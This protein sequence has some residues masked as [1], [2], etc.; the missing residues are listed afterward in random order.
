M[1]AAYGRYAHFCGSLGLELFEPLSFKGR[2][3]SGRAGDRNGYADASLRP[4]SGDWEK[5]LYTYRLWGRLLYNPEATPDG[6][7][8][9]LAAEFGPAAAD[10]E[11][12]LASASRV[13][14]LVTTA[15][16]PSAS[17]NAF[18]PEI[19][20]N[21]PIVDANRPHHYGDTPSP[22]RFGTVSPLDPAL[23][24]TVEECAEELASGRRTGRYSPLEVARWLD[25]FTQEAATR[26]A[27][28]RTLAPADDPRFRRLAIDVSIQAGLGRFFAEKLR[29]AVAY[30]I[31]DKTHGTAA[32]REA[33][34][35]YR[36][37][38]DAWAKL[39]AE[40][41]GIYVD[42]LTFGAAPHL[43]GHWADRLAAIDA[44]LADMDAE[45]NQASVGGPEQESGS[46]LLVAY[47]EALTG[48]GD[49]TPRCQHQPPPSFRP[50]ES[51][52]IEITSDSGR[53]LE[54]VRLHYR[55][56]NQAEEYQVVP[57]SA[58]GGRWRAV[59]PA[60]YTDSPYPL[61][62]YFELHDA[63][64]AAW[65]YP[66]LGENLT[67]QPYFVIRRGDKLPACPPV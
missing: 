31:Y 61:L 57:M 30:A 33:M 36:P 6:W 42:D 54:S 27:R 41:Q 16:D 55:H 3:G 37:A 18:W 44:D 65:L 15:H 2:K 19:Y 51:V 66:G 63:H 5:H 48:R 60:S 14:P 56:V 29:A 23:F 58:E 1:A 67:N 8:R 10:C 25:R 13:L 47:T 20:T 24:T 26:L 45:R 59:L 53:P 9:F 35:R 32:I 34:S 22:R 43:R 49:S 28:A 11:A 12:A 4:V 38:R 21:M 7:R 52:A 50:G 62:Y 46:A 17:N 64:G 40:A 39:A